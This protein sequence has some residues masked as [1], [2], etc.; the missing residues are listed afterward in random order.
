MSIVAKISAG[1]VEHQQFVVNIKA[2]KL[3]DEPKAQSNKYISMWSM[4]DKDKLDFNK[5]IEGC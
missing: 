3:K 5:A 1:A 2:E 4:F